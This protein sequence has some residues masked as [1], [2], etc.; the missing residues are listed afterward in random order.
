MVE[1]SI[2]LPAY[3]EGKRI[4]VTIEK[5]LDYFHS[6][7]TS[8]EIIV[9]D[10]GSKDK[11]GEIFED[12]SKKYPKVKILRH[13]TNL[14]K[15]ATVKTGILEAKGDYIFFS[16]ADLSTPIEEIEK[17]LRGVKEEGYDIAIGSRGLPDSKI[18]VPQPWYRQC[19]GRFFPWL[20]RF[21][22]FQDIKDTQCGFKLFKK[23][24]AR[25]LFSL[26]RIT[27]FS[28]DVEILYLAKKRGYRVKEIPVVWS[29]SP[30]S[31]VRILRDSFLMLKDL[32]RIRFIHVKKIAG[33]GN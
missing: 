4:G 11:G 28:F 16:D 15:G 18:L 24:V 9:V 2:I 32:L 17:L 23:D 5:I 8:F 30:G 26:Q 14:G 3:N 19:I 13:R 1:L 27:G 7:N 33:S 31:K 22:V 29:D 6:R 10:D 25:E 21:I 12:F 20:V